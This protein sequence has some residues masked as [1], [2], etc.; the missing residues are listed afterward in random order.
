M[1]PNNGGVPLLYVLH[2][3]NLY[4]TER[5]ALATAAGVADEFAVTIFAPPGPALR[6]AARMGFGAVPFGGA[7]DVA[8]K[9]MPY[10]AR[11]RRLAFIATG[12]IHSLAAAAWSTLWHRRLPHLHI[13]HGGADERDSYGR[14]RRLN[15]LGVVFVA[16]SC[17]VRARL[18]A[19]GVAASTIRVIAIFCPTPSWPRRRGARLF[20]APACGGCWWSR[21]WIRKS[22]SIY[23]S[24]PSIASR[25]CAP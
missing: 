7:R 23:C 25:R 2:S 6:E 4:G 14:K 21:A 8:M 18:V 16:V 20:A 10:F 19:N 11:N 3:G 1:R 22:A 12:V 24:T 17:F 5:M 9:L 15:R 13:V